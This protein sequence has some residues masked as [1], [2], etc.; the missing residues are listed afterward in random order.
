MHSAGRNFHVHSTEAVLM[1]Q[2]TYIGEVRWNA[3]VCTVVA[4]VALLYER[5]LCS[6]PCMSYGDMATGCARRA[7]QREPRL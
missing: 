2:L 3:D 1:V 7:V 6:Y 4:R 5:G